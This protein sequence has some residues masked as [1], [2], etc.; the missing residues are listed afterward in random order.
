MGFFSKIAKSFKRITRKILP[1]VAKIAPFVPVLQPFSPLIASAAQRA[2]RQRG[3]IG[4]SQGGPTGRVV[5]PA[6][7]TRRGIPSSNFLRGISPAENRG[8][9]ASILLAQAAFNR[10]PIAGPSPA[11]LPTRVPFINPT[12]GVGVIGPIFSGTGGTQMAGIGTLLTGIGRGLFGG[13]AARAGGALVTGGAA[14]NL[15][16]SSTGRALSVITATGQRIGRK[17]VVALAKSIGLQAAAAALG[18]GLV[19]IA[20]MTADELGRPRRRRGITA[21]DFAT[22]RR[23]M[24]KIKTMHAMLPTRGT[25]RRAPTHHHHPRSGVV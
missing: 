23:T 17:R 3:S 10:G 13:G 2:T 12:P 7:P 4:I 22:T 25:T 11:V 5:A 14:G 9:D 16:L 19:E 8:I 24:T 20:T 21:R 15:I 6:V 1:V 18:I